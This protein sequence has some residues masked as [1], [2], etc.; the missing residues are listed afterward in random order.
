MRGPERSPGGPAVIASRHQEETMARLPY[1][2]REALPEEFR[3]LWDRAM[4]LPETKAPPNIFRALGNN[5]AV[6]QQ[7]LRLGNALWTQSGIDPATRELI[8]LRTAI[9][10]HS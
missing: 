1:T 4:T 6:W 7:Y 3:Y 10:A 2:S 8:I 9:L 5:P